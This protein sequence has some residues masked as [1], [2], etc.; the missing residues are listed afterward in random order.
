MALLPAN[1]YDAERI[2][3]RTTGNFTLDEAIQLCIVAGVPTLIPRHFGLSAFNAA[4]PAEID[5]A[6]RRTRHPRLLRPEDR[7]LFRLSPDG[8]SQ[9]RP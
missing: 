1:G 2:S 7:H 4:N 3:N 6:A 8:C 5:T 9:N